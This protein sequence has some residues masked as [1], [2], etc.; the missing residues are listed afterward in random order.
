[1]LARAPTS[2]PWWARRHHEVGIGFQPLGHHDRLLV[3]AAE[4]A[5]V[6]RWPALD[7][8]LADQLTDAGP[9]YAGLDDARL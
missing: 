8:V 3:A 7:L 4:S 6:G 1:M 9:L 5:S 2:I